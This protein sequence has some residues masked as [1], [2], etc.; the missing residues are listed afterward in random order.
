MLFMAEG[1]QVA[2]ITLDPADELHRVGQALVDYVPAS[3]PWLDFLLKDAVEERAETR[4][5]RET[6]PVH[7]A[8]GSL[9]TRSGLPQRCSVAVQR[10]LGAGRR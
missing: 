1:Y 3:G 10:L 2:S 9:T 7:L 5:L 6:G 4:W 8:S